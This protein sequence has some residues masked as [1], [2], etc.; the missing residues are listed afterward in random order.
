MG[1]SKLTNQHKFL[2]E[3]IKEQER[4]Q[5]ISEIM[6]SIEPDPWRYSEPPPPFTGNINYEEMRDL[7]MWVR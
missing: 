7:G 2:H 6:D 1:E 5:L 4:K 3:L